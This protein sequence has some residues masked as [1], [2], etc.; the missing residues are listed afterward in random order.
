MMNFD[1]PR[2]LFRLLRRA[3]SHT[4]GLMWISWLTFPCYP[5]QYNRYSSPCL[6][7]VCP[8]IPRSTH[9]AACRFVCTSPTHQII[10]TVVPQTSALHLLC[11]W[12][13]IAIILWHALHSLS[14][15]GH[16]PYRRSIVSDNEFWHPRSSYNHHA[17]PISPL[18]SRPENYYIHTMT[19]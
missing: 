15:L 18:D 14:I 7:L 6:P 13:F 8:L 4:I 5:A 2:S 12:C 1:H 3:H 9:M 10:C 16:W 17:E 19:A 11:I